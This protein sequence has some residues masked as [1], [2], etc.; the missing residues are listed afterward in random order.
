MARIETD[1]NYTT[2][3]FSRATAATDLFKKEDV[4]NLAAAVSTHDHSTGKG[5]TIPF[6][7]SI[8]NGTITSVMIA[9]GTIDTADLKDGSVTS[10]KIADG[11]I[12]T[13]DLANAS[14]T[15][16]KLASDVARANLLTNGGFEIWQRGTGPFTANGAWTADRWMISLGGASTISV[17]RDSTFIDPNG[18]VFAA[19]VT[20]THAAESY[21]AQSV[22]EVTGQLRGRT[23]TYSARVRTAT[24]SAVRL[25][26]TVTGGAGVVYGSYHTGDSTFQTLSVTTPVAA[27]ATGV[28]V[29]VVFN[30][31][32]SAYIDNA[33]L[34]V[35]SVAADYAPLHPAD[36]LARCLRYYEVAGATYSTLIAS[37]QCYAATA[38]VF[39]W[40]FKVRKAVTPVITVVGATGLYVYNAGAANQALTGMTADSLAVDSVRL[41]PSV[42]SGLVA[43]N[44]TILGS[45]A[46]TSYVVAEANP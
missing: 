39:P 13:G 40:A 37:G 31:S 41:L 11:T 35:G 42:A 27:G 17:G 10:A 21:L 5:V 18:S 3:T 38:A 43:G 46:A 24:A 36:D 33:M 30:A 29:N 34:V 6:A 16:A 45:S 32:C 28:G 8:P 12:A 15:N 26:V 22:L 9:D 14:V 44:A 4:Q 19:A 7:S 2:P 1:P 25:A 20:Y 23:V